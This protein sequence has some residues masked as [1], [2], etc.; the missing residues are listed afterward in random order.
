MRAE[1]LVGGL[2]G[3]AERWKINVAKLE[4]DKKCLIG[5]IVLASA[6]VAY[7]GPFT[8]EY[9]IKLVKGWIEKCK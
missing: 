8:S 4:E 7:I 9:R 3:E 1:K 5:N 6:S 2:S